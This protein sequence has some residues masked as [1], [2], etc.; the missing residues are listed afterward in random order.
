MESTTRLPPAPILP[1]MDL[2]SYMVLLI[3]HRDK[4]DDLEGACSGGNFHFNCV[5]FPFVQKAP[6]DWRSR[7]D[8]AC[9]DVG[10]FACYQLVG[11]LLILIHIQQDDLRTKRDSIPRNL[12]EINH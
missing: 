10:I 4:A 11:D 9:G 2:G 6:A 12:V 1:V 8:E 3:V 7:R 5:A